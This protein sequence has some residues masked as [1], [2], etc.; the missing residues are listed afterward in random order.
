MVSLDLEGSSRAAS[1]SSSRAVLRVRDTG[2]GM[3]AEILSRV[4]EPFV[5]S[6][7]SLDRSGGGLGLGLALVKGLV[8]LHGGA[9]RAVSE[10]VGKGTELVVELPLDTAEVSRAA[11]MRSPAPWVARRVLVIEDS[12]DSAETLREALG[13]SSGTSS[14]SRGRAPRGSKRR[15]LSGPMRSSATSAFP[16]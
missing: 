5:Q 12:A 6:D 8:E 7:R 16:G 4:F 13:S 2:V 9:V 3:G 11:A 10:G 14:R 1:G 15:G